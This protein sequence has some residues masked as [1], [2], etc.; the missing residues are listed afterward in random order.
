MPMFSRHLLASRRK[1]SHILDVEFFVE[2][3][4]HKSTPVKDG[5]S[6]TCCD[7]LTCEFT[8]RPSLRTDT[9]PIEPSRL[10]VLRVGI[11]VAILGMAKL[12]ACQQHWRPVREHH[13]SD[14]VALLP[15][16]KSRDLRIICWP[17]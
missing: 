6:P 16:S 10:V 3:S 12:V 15:F 4:H 8:Q 9:E 17:L 2:R 1:P 5:K 7:Q 14:Q 13:G 11:V